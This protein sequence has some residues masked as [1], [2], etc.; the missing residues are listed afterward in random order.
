MAYE[1]DAT[2]RVISYANEPTPAETKCI[3]YRFVSVI[4][5]YTALAY[6]I[7]KKNNSARSLVFRSILYAKASF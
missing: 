6:N 3:L 5:R 2:A 4:F 1:E 7:E